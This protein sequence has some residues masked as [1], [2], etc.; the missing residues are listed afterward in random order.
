MKGVC[1]AIGGSFLLSLLLQGHSEELSQR[2]INSEIAVRLDAIVEKFPQGAV[3]SIIVRNGETGAVLYA[4]NNNQNLMPA[5]VQ[6][7][8]TAIAAYDRLGSDFRYSTEV[9]SQAPASPS[10]NIK[11]GV[12]F[13]FTGD[14][15][16]TRDNLEHL[17]GSM[18]KQGVK[19]IEGTLWLDGSR[20]E[21][22]ASAEGVVWN[23]LKICFA[24]PS[25]AMILNR[26]CF[27]ALLKPA[28]KVGRQ[29]V[30][31][32][33]RPEWP[34]QLINE[35]LTGSEGDNTCEPKS[36]DAEQ[37]RY[38]LTGCV[39]KDR[40][41][42]RMAFAVK[43][44]EQAIK[45]FV[46]KTLRQKGIIHNGAVVIGQ[47]N[48]SFTH[49]L[50][51][52]H[53]EPLSALLVF[54]LATSDN[55]YADSIIKTLGHYHQLQAGTYENGVQALTGTLEHL[56]ASLESGHVE[57]GSGLSRYNLV[58]ASALSGVLLAGWRK[59]GRDMP[60]LQGTNRDY[61]YK[62]GRMKDVRAM[63]GYVFPKN[64]T[65]K[66]FVILLNGLVPGHDSS[67]E[68]ATRFWANIRE[69][70]QAFINELLNKSS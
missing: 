42:L 29:A 55:L 64:G 50:A 68:K 36:W 62:T 61:W 69:Q 5:S 53:S 21:G 2:M 6:K 56:G 25:T 23:D 41:P 13:L 18:K 28:G 8:S 34:F 63:A 70:Q 58:S 66:V 26:N 20:Y 10:G 35:V 27:Y 14:P 49:K 12:Q 17:L 45:Q 48:T 67:T 7:V 31:E 16:L 60:W 32:Y 47:P 38:Q 40:S 51:E 3:S 54:M 43:K 11:G 33:A 46:E 24:A 65:L 39:A 37:A 22:Y 57:D 59:W 1:K 19:R 4:K 15:S 30:I 9:L 44:P 52:H